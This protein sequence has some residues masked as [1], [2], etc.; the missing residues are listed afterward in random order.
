MVS[1]RK[2]LIRKMKNIV[3]GVRHISVWF[4]IGEI[5]VQDVSLE[6]VKF[7]ELMT[8]TK[9]GFVPYAIKSGN[10]SESCMIFEL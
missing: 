10:C 2:N 4:S 1:L 9:D 8:S 3:P 7:V 5:I 6:Y